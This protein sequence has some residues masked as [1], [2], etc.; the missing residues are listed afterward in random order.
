MFQPH[1]KGAG[2]TAARGGSPGSR[3][4]HPRTRGSEVQLGCDAGLR[5]TGVKIFPCHLFPHACYFLPTRGPCPQLSGPPSFFFQTLL[6]VSW[7]TGPTPREKQGVQRGEEGEQELPK[8]RDKNK[9]ESRLTHLTS[10]WETNFTESPPGFVT[11]K[12]G[13]AALWVF[14]CNTLSMPAAS[15]YTPGAGSASSRNGNTPGVRRA[16]GGCRDCL[17]PG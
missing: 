13:T 6:S 12:V 2:E 8:G 9:A 7:L 17:F 16:A 1:C 10:T 11:G 14:P 15:S 3:N 4:M 5:E